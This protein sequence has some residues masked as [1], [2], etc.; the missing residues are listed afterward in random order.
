MI[1]TV[2]YRFGVTLAKSNNSKGLIFPI[3]AIKAAIK[4]PTITRILFAF[5]SS[6]LNLSISC[7]YSSLYI[8]KAAEYFLSH[9]ELVLDS[10]IVLLDERLIS[11][12][13]EIFAMFNSDSS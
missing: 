12:E 2:Q 4:K 5:S 3:S 13:N 10:S 9:S 6:V 1:V 8:S 11:N 7:R